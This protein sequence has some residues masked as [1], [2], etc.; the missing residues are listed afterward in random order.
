[1]K[2]ENIFGKIMNQSEIFKMAHRNTKK[3]FE[4]GRA[5]G[6][7]M[8]IFSV[9]LTRAYMYNNQ[10][11]ADFVEYK[12][13]KNRPEYILD[14]P[15]WLLSKNL[16]QQEMQAMDT[17]YTSETVRETPK[18][19]LIAFSTDFG[20]ITCWVPKSVIKKHVA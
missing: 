14:V 5:E 15:V 10:I 13:A 6:D 12:A 4:D 9:Y 19:K 8:A 18:A 16:D 7:Y 1:M 17:A 2:L 11:K 3:A 20:R